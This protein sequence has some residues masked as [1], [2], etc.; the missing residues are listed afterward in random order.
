MIRNISPSD[1]MCDKN[2]KVVKFMKFSAL[3][4]LLLLV[5]NGG[6]FRIYV[7]MVAPVK[8]MERRN[9]V[10]AVLSMQVD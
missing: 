10:S 1:V 3:L 8:M 9:T 2:S 5:S 6:W 7:L 4:M